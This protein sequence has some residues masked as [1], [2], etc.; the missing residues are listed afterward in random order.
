MRCPE[1]GRLLRRRMKNDRVMFA[2]M[3]CNYEVAPLIKR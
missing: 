2:C 3:R 1:C